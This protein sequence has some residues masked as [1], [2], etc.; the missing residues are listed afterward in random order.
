[1]NCMKRLLGSGPWLWLLIIFS[2]GRAEAG[3]VMKPTR[4]VDTSMSATPS[5]GQQIDVTPS[6]DWDAN[7]TLLQGAIDR[8]SAGNIIN[9]HPGI[10]RCGSLQLKNKSGNGWITI[11]SSNTEAFLPAEGNRVSPTDHSNM[12]V[13]ISAGSNA[14]AIR[15]DSGAHNYRLIGLEVT[16][17]D[18]KAFVQELVVIDTDENLG[19]TQVDNLAD[20]P[21]DIIVDRCYIHGL[22]A[23]DLKR[24]IRIY[25]FNCAVIDSYI[26]EAHVVGQ[27]AQ[28]ILFG[29]GPLTIANNYLEAAGENLFAM[30][31]LS[32][33]T[34]NVSVATTTSAQLT[35]TRDLRVGDAMSFYDG[36]TRLFTHIT[37]VSGQ[38][39]TY[40]PLSEQPSSQ[41]VAY[42]GTLPTDIDIKNNYLF[43]P[44]SWNPSDLSYVGYHP[45]V[46]NLFELKSG[47]RVWFHNNVLENNWIDGQ[48]GTAILLTVRNQYNQCYFCTVEDITIDSNIVANAYN[49]IS[50]LATDNLDVSGPTHNVLITNNLFTKIANVCEQGSIDEQRID[51]NTMS[52][53]GY[54]LSVEYGASRLGN[55]YTNN[56]AISTWAS[57]FH[58]NDGSIPD[59]SMIFPKWYLQ[60]NVFTAING[61]PTFV[62]MKAWQKGNYDLNSADEIS[63]VD[64]KNGDFTLASSSWARGAASDGSDLGADVAQLLQTQ[65]KVM[66]GIS[67]PAQPS[68]PIATPPHRVYETPKPDS[69]SPTPQSDSSSPTPQSDSSS[70]TPQANG[71]SARSQ[72]EDPVASSGFGSATC[73]ISVATDAPVVREKTAVLLRAS[74]SVPNATGTM[75]TFVVDGQALSTAITDERGGASFV[76]R[77]LTVG[78]HMVVADAGMSACTSPSLTVTVTPVPGPHTRFTVD[79]LVLT[80]SKIGKV[81]VHW[82]VPDPSRVEVRVGAPDGPLFAAGG[83]SGSAETGM[84]VSDGLTFFLQRTG[85]TDPTQTLAF[86]T[87]RATTPQLAGTLRISPD[88]MFTTG[89]YGTAQLTWSAAMATTVEL[90]VGSPDGP[91]LARGGPSG[92]VTTGAWVVD[93]TTFFLQD[94]SNPQNSL[95]TDYTI[96]T[97]TAQ[98]LRLPEVGYLFISPLKAQKSTGSQE[99]AEATV[100]WNSSTA[101]RVEIR[102]GAPNGPLFAAGDAQGTATVPGWAKTGQIFFMQDV[103]EQQPLS[104]AFTIATQTVDLSADSQVLFQAS[105]NPMLVTP[106]FVLG[107]TTVYWEGAGET[108]EV[109]V[110]TP[111][112]PLVARGGSSGEAPV[113]GWGRGGT[114]LYLVDVSNRTSNKVLGTLTLHIA[115]IR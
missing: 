48:D 60:G 16:K 13:I 36:T 93:G 91:L 80:D 63:F 5:T 28:A 77:E 18:P 101:D 90:H 53:G 47:R 15:T 67:G 105:P 8:A 75:I 106:G 102:L 24:G 49:A 58:Y 85:N 55:V 114:V 29:G 115:A 19:E 51:H 3:V 110:G 33:R 42:W 97:A 79:P 73:S 30:D 56:I 74:I 78:S 40:E 39:I 34:A 111:D 69:S 59:W 44:L 94:R 20:F 71:S 9:V 76:T 61:M 10:Y 64:W 70:P 108:T 26:S 65:S 32:L 57:G 66:V 46:K 87:A 96:A 112:G 82:D 27:E 98:V 72:P 21:H 6:S 17:L 89:Q 12:P 88:P 83:S 107:S 41:T 95:T 103:T 14:P 113:E 50:V 11:K 109:H 92:T 81:A 43:K 7:C 62:Y 2:V 35:S 22:P 25:C 86:V 31:F 45:T 68:G 54:A 4:Y 23:N 1:M 38:S 52:I 37:S 99:G 84:W 104:S 100:R